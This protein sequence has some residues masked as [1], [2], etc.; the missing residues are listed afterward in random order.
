MIERINDWLRERRIA[1]YRA[2]MERCWGT[3]RQRAWAYGDMMKAE[4]KLRSQRQ[5]ARMESRL[6]GRVI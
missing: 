1:K 6:M 3:D 4:I 5:I 2:E